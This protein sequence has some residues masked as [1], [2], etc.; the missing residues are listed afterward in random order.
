MHVLAAPLLMSLLLYHSIVN[1]SAPPFT[2]S[3]DLHTCSPWYAERAPVLPTL[4]ECNKA[5]DFLRSGSDV[6]PF[7]V[8]K[9]PRTQNVS[10]YRIVQL[11]VSFGQGADSKAFEDVRILL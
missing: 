9:T 5:T 4:A 7:W 8:K 3:V 2:D 6:V 10:H 11:T 1:I